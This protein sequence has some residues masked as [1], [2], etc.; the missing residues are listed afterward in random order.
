M[1]T[2]NLITFGI[3]LHPQDLRDPFPSSNLGKTGFRDLSPKL[4]RAGF[5]FPKLAVT[6]FPHNEGESW[7]GI[8]PSTEELGGKF[9][10]MA[11]INAASLTSKRGRAAP[12]GSVD[13][14]HPRGWEL[15]QSRLFSRLWRVPAEPGAHA[16]SRLLLPRT[17]GAGAG[18]VQPQ[19][20]QIQQ[21]PAGKT[22]G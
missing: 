18:Q 21:N 15:W 8:L 11:L 2:P 12:W 3:S 4:S 17:P 7:D 14:A 1:P 9:T 16:R 5:T 6:L 19:N 13:P 20:P 22:P 10:L